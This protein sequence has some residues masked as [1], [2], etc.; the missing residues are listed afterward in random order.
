LKICLAGIHSF[1]EEF[2]VV[3]GFVAVDAS[4]YPFAAAIHVLDHHSFFK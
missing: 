2:V 3:E 4:V 1:A